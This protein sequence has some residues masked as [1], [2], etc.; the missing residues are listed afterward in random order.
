LVS[1]SFINRLAYQPLRSSK[2]KSSGSTILLVIPSCANFRPMARTV[3]RSWFVVYVVDSYGSTKNG[4]F[5]G[6]IASKWTP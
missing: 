1:G 2:I 6:E 3:S 5:C 4:S